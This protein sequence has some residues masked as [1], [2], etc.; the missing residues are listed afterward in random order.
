MTSLRSR[1]IFLVSNTFSGGS[2][3][4]RAL[5]GYKLLTEDVSQN[6]ITFLAVDVVVINGGFMTKP[7]ERDCCSFPQ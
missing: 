1:A 7:R 5:E 6:K 2:A 3:L 4:E